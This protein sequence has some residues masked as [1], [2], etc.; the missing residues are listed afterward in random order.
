MSRGIFGKKFKQLCSDFNIKCT[1][2]EVPSQTASLELLKEKKVDAATFNNL[3]KEVYDESDINKT[4]IMYSPMKIVF[5]SRKGEN[6]KVLDA[7]DAAIGEWRKTDN[8]FIMNHLQN[9]W[10]QQKFTKSISLLG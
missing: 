10:A 2:V 4:S 3:F 6:H 7:I 9:R 8:L 5:P 1:F